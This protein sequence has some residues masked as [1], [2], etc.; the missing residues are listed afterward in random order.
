MTNK[1]LQISGKKQNQREKKKNKIC[2]YNGLS[3]HVSLHFHFDVKIMKLSI[4]G[5]ELYIAFSSQSE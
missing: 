3:Y 2:G 4:V 1:R 5:L